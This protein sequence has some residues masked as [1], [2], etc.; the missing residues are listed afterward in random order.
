MTEKMTL[1]DWL[2]VTLRRLG[3]RLMFNC[4]IWKALQGIASNLEFQVE[5]D[6][7]ADG[8]LAQIVD[9]RGEAE[10]TQVSS[11]SRWIAEETC[12]WV[13]MTQ[14]HLGERPQHDFDAGSN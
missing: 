5:I 12:L 11:P 13:L 1:R 7:T 4:S 2:G 3:M 10:T 14:M 8:W 9:R 6:K